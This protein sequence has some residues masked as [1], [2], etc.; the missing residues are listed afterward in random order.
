MFVNG[1]GQGKPFSN[2][3]FRTIW[4]GN[5]IDTYNFSN[6]TT[7]LSVDLNP[8]RWSNLDTSGGHFQQAHLG[9]NHYA[10]GHVFNALQYKGD[11]RS[12]IENAYGGIGNDRII[13]NNANNYLSG[14][15]GNDNI[16][17]GWGND[18]LIGGQGN[19]AL[20]G[21]GN[22]DYHDGGLGNDYIDGWNGNDNLLGGSGNDNLLGGGDNDNLFGGSGNDNLFGGSGNDSLV[23]SDPNA[24][25]SGSGEIDVLRGDEGADFFILG[26]YWEAY[27]QS[28]G[29]D[30]AV[31]T[32]FNATQLDK[33]RVH[34]SIN[35]YHLS[36]DIAWGGT[37]IQYEGNNVAWVQNTTD[38]YLSRDFEFVT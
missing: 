22:H 23:G 37:W 7:N 27:Y 17:G 11:S 18:N 4:D 21:G 34:G 10:R 16:L 12:L 33:F 20:Y 1:V 36:F 9:N 30:Y 3:I 29:A 25:N 38:V 8:G 13:G 15:F 6:Y 5:G 32:D 14:N 31:I 24:W 19:D 28:G 2:R 26:D 35:N